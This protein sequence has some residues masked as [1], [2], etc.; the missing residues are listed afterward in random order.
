MINKFIK[1][2]KTVIILLGLFG[3]FA[4]FSNRVLASDSIGSDQSNEVAVT[5][6]GV[7]NTQVYDGH[8]AYIGGQFSE[9]S[10]DNGVNSKR[11]YFA[12]VDVLSSKVNDWDLQL[13]NSVE[14]ILIDGQMIVLAGKFTKSGDRDLPYIAFFDKD[15]H[16]KLDIDIK[17]DAPVYAIL[18]V[19]DILYFGG[20]FKTVNDQKR[21]F[22]ASYILPNKVL[23]TW[24]PIVNDT[25]F[26]IKL[27]KTTLFVAGAFTKIDGLDRKYV[28]AFDLI[29][30][31]L[32]KY[33]PQVSKPVRFLNI[34]NS[35]ESSDLT[36]IRVETTIPT[37]QFVID[38][39][40]EDPV[41]FTQIEPTRTVLASQ[42]DQSPNSCGFVNFCGEN[43]FCNRRTCY[44][45]LSLDGSFRLDYQWW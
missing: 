14:D 41:I 10:L 11:K 21:S 29:T 38:V 5:V 26:D 40:K 20:D 8:K 2:F 1:S 37:N 44:S 16:A 13:D 9:V 33:N 27:Y 24:S 39:K 30:G 43:V 12:E 4:T 7:V 15:S 36:Q 25:I 45:I 6:N 42:N 34:T 23:T 19:G 17:I 28:G 22:L 31:K 35:Q 32:T 18:K 3:F